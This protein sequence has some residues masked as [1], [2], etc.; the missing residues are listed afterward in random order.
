MPVNWKGLEDRLVQAIKDRQAKD[1]DSFAKLIVDEYDRAVV[2]NGQDNL[3][4]NAVTVTNKS[5]FESALRSAFTLAKLARSASEAQNVMRTF[6]NMGIIGYW[7]GG[8]LGFTNPPPGAVS[9]VTNMVVFPGVPPDVKISN[10]SKPEVF[11]RELVV[12]LQSHAM[13]VNIVTSGVT[14]SGVPVVLSI[15]GIN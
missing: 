4:G 1:E 9:V 10:A 3:L 8:Q 5:I 6:I 2:F 11:V 12:R 14:S 13:T 15:S 7:M